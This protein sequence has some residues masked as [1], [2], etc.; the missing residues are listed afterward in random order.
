[1]VPA[2]DIKPSDSLLELVRPLTRDTSRHA[3]SL[4]I[5]SDLV[6]FLQYL[7]KYLGWLKI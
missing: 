4:I 7:A 3:V 2:A 6:P 1:M 5:N